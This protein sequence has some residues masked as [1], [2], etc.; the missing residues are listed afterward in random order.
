MKTIGETIILSALGIALTACGPFTPNPTETPVPAEI[1][2]PASTITPWPTNIPTLEIVD[3]TP[4]HIVASTPTA[5]AQILPTLVDFEKL[6][7]LSDVVV[8]SVDFES[9]VTTET[10]RYNT[11]IRITDLTNELKDSCL[12]DCAK[13]RYS[14]K[15]GTF[16]IMLLRAGDHPKAENTSQNLRQGFLKSAGQYEYTD[17]DIP[18]MPLGSWAFVTYS[19]IKYH[20]TGATGIAHGSIVILV[21]YS[22]IATD[23][24]MDFAIY[25]VEFLNVQ[26]QKLEAAGYPK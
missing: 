19:D 1:V 20:A 5:T 8:S 22:H 18:T 14:L 17:S 3:I 16:T 12:W 24:I 11:L 6:P 21:T 2:L 26:I 25:P 23:D 7:R 9:F 10:F 4:A 13:Y 15:Y